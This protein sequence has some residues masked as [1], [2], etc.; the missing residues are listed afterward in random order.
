MK[1]VDNREKVKS[2]NRN[3]RKQSTQNFPE[4]IHFLPPVGVRNNNISES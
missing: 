2:Q 1:T 3:K 4:S